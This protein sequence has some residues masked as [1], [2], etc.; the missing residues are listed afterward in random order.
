MSFSIIGTGS[1]L[2]KTIQTN[3]DLTEFLETS[4]E[5]IVS[6]T[7]IEARHICVEES[8][9]DIALDASLNALDN[10]QLKPQDLDLIICPTLGGDTVT[11]SLACL[12]E[13]ELGAACPS[14]DLNAACS[15]FV[16][17]L[18]VADA[19]FSRNKQMKILVIA[20]DAMS[21]LVNWKDRATAVLFGDGAGAAV[22][23]SGDDLKAIHL[24]AV[25]NQHALCI[26]WQ[27][28]NHP[29]LRNQET[30]L[31]YLKMDGS[32]VYR[33]AVSAICKDLK[34]VV[35]EAGITLDD[36]DYVIPHQANLRIIE[37]AAKRLKIPME[38][39]VLQVSFCGNTSAASI[40]LVLDEMNRQG[41][42][43]PGTRIALTAFGGG[44][45]TG[46]CILEWS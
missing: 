13:K 3:E 40:P 35:K 43:I 16:Y 41:K 6:R 12:V 9:L 11:P 14:F 23:S 30:L 33:F 24:T 28:G 15:G 36:L 25:G 8:I 22:L 38:K 39:F 45:T 26:P 42:L 32:E 21:K 27:K 29:L 7:G 4:N 10:A 17:G 20:V 1:A 2:P 5:W 31:P 18:D 19:Y 46:A 44:L 34:I 37:S